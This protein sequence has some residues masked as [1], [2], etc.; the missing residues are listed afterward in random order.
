[1]TTS[2]GGVGLSQQE[3]EHLVSELARI[4]GD[5]DEKVRVSAVK[6]VGTFNLRDAVYKLGASGGVSKSGSVLGNISERVR[7]KKHT[8]RAEA[9]VVLG[10]LW[11]VAAGAIA[12]GE[13]EIVSVLAAA[14][15]KILDTYYANDLDINALLDRVLFEQLLPLNF[16]PIKSQTTKLTNGN[17]QSAKS[18]ELLKNAD[19]ERVD[20]DRIRTERILVLVRDLDERAKKI[21]F[22]VQQRQ[23]L[24]SK[25]VDAFL[26]RCADYNGGVMEGNEKEIKDHM[27]RLIDSLARTMP[28]SSKVT[29]H[30]WK[31]AKMHDKRCYALIRYCM[32]HD[33]SQSG[34]QQTCDYRTIMKAMKEFNKRINE[35]SSAP[36]D[37]L[38]TMTPLL[39]RVSA[40]VYNKSHVPAVMEYART[41][42]K[43][44]GA[45]AQ[46]ILREIST[47]VPEILKAHVQDLC[48]ALQK[49]APTSTKPN[50]PGTVDNLKAC[51]AFAAKFAEEVPKDRKFVQAVTAFALYGAPPEAAKH[52]VA[53]LMNS[54][55]KKELTAKDIVRKCV[56][57]FEY[58]TNGFLSKLAA[59]SELVLLAP[60][61][62]NEEAD[63][64][65][66]ITI[67]Q[68]LLQNRTPSEA[69]SD[70][71]DWGQ[72]VDAE[73]EAKC[74]SLKFLVNRV[75]SHA[76]SETLAEAADPVYKLLVKLISH[77]GEMTPAANTPPICKSRLRLLAARQCL[78]LCLK[79]P[80]D[81]L[82]SPN[83]FNTLS[84]VAQDPLKEVRSSFLQRLKKY[85]GQQRL[86]QRFYTIPFLLAFEPSQSLKLDTMTWIR[87][88]SALFTAAR[89]EQGPKAPPVMESVFARLVSVLAHHPDYAAGAEDLTEFARYLIFYLQCVASADNI[90][91]IYSIAQRVKQ[92]RDAITPS[93]AVD[94]TLYHLSDLAQLTIRKFED[95][96][97]WNIQTLPGRISLPRSLYTEIKEHAKAQKIAEQNFLPEGVDE[98]VEAIVKQ[99]MRTVRV[100]SIKRRSESE[101]GGQNRSAKKV[102]SAVH[103]ANTSKRRKPEGAAAHTVKKSKSKKL[104]TGDLSSPSRRRSGRVAVGSSGKYA[105]RDDDDD[106]EEMAEGVAEWRYENEDAEEIV[107]NG[108]L[109]HDSD[110]A[111]VVDGKSDEEDEFDVPKSPP[112]KAASKGKKP[113]NAP[114]SAA[115]RAAGKRKAR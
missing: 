89:L 40:I 37:L 90:S 42:E 68:I 3:E 87:S 91:L 52:A 4:L 18:D 46:E 112:S 93:S 7:D 31:F 54:S 23:L 81:A 48:A 105:E 76:D 24:L 53:I 8:V 21:F 11:G 86:P 100:T 58:G 10:R 15:S 12:D 70:A 111:D 101:A 14:P 103:K 9:M 27:S 49:E 64:I 17:L 62:A 114:N 99:S 108:D 73:C 20:P 110:E 104:D 60:D 61:Q 29:E 67:E 80:T 106:D 2:A 13:G 51:A 44:L 19:P 65:S 59:L 94:E 74:W 16:P 50:S 38:N 71:Y 55:D 6:A 98:G 45:T 22:A 5:A 92:C 36:N 79:K 97:G 34:E 72:S 39:Y 109:D 28:D 66:G 47:R 95:V 33:K 43:S 82:L 35:S 107:G 88:R 30:L 57:D 115:S 63:D 77:N 84:L 25:V 75:R 69:G 78:K 102:K 26:Q 41:N 96:H 56:K 1:M 83:A 85:L 32:G 113:A